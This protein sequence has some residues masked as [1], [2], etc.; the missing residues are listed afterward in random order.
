[1]VLSRQQKLYVALAAVFVTCLVLGDLIGGKAFA[2]TV[3]LGDWTYV[4]PVSVGLFAFPVTFLLTD[5]V[6]EFYG[7]A[8]ARFLTFVGMWVAVFAYVILQ[9]AMAPAAEP[10]S[11]F[12]DGEFN[13]VF[14]IGGTLFVA[15]LVAY[16]CGQL[17]DIS[18]FAFWKTL[19]N[20]RHLWLRA[21]G[22][23]LASQLV[24]TFIINLLFWWVF[25][26]AS[27]GG[28]R[29]LPWVLT[30][31]TG[32]YGI[33]VLIA[34]GLTPVI[35]VLHELVTRRLGIAPAPVHAGANGDASGELAGV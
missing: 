30:K 18:V 3:G 13:K 19:T 24:D 27:S 5:L 26:A 33:K 35:Y 8:G 20:S 12:Q 14:G 4:Q 31:A 9:V 15:S 6:N 25:P 1:M 7:R 22:S 16:L 34:V 23:T 28:A 17:L 2:I 11:Y 32:E 21:T 29:P 10:N